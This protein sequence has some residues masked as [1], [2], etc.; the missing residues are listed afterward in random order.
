MRELDESRTRNMYKGEELGKDGDCQ[1]V[2]IGRR[3]AS[4]KKE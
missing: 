4:K 3:H 2:A 1:G